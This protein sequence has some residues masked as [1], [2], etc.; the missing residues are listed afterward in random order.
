MLQ[1]VE[2]YRDLTPSQY[3]EGY[4]WLRENNFLSTEGRVTCSDD[5]GEAILKEAMKSALWFENADTIFDR[6]DDLPADIDLAAG[7]LDLSSDRA[8]ELI[9]VE[10]YIFDA[11][12]RKEIG[13]LGEKL[14]VSYL[15]EIPG[16]EVEQVSLV[17][18]AFGYDISLKIQSKNYHLE[19]KSTTKINTCQ[20]YLSRN[21]WLVSKIDPNWHLIYVTINGDEI[22]NLH[23]VPRALIYDL[24]PTNQNPQSRW[25]SARFEL[26]RSELLYGFQHIIR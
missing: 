8:A 24:A 20:F 25:E 14:L 4:R 1:S 22:M 18:D 11:A 15:Q 10:W 19:V 21:E 23:E 13:L 2:S 3:D 12:K 7:S 16:A 5:Y 26:S 6:I 17:S 9:R